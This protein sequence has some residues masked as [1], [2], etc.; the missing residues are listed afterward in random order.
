MLTLISGA[1][2]EIRT[3]AYKKNVRACY[4]SVC[5]DYAKS[6]RQNFVKDMQTL[7]T[8]LG[9]MMS[10]VTQRIRYPYCA[11]NIEFLCNAVAN[12]RDLKGGFE[13]LQLNSMGNRVKHTICDAEIDMEL[14]VEVYNELVRTIANQYHLPALTELMLINKNGNKP[15]APVPK[16]NAPTA[17]P[18]G[19]NV[20]SSTA[21]VSDERIKM[22]VTLERGTGRYTKGI[23]KKVGMVNF[24]IGVSISNPDNL[25]IVSVDAVLR[26]NKDKVEKK[27]S[28]ALES[29]TEIDLETSRFSGNIIVT[30]MATY[31]IGLFKTKKVTATVS[32]N[33]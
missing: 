11:Q 12:R 24:V 18:T 25:P 1:N 19:K 9:Q 32:N 21:A 7:V 14:C 28:K 10:I 4:L 2:N 23:I 31:K 3:L 5:E 15:H 29:T 33:F 20:P 17:K 22:R 30:V 26:S 13:Y 27:L 16:Q 6:Y 8:K